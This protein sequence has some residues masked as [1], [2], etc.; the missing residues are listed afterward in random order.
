[1]PYKNSNHKI[2]NRLLIFITLFFITYALKAQIT[3][4]KA[5]PPSKVEQEVGLSKIT[6]DYS[7]PSVKGR[8]IFGDLVPYGR[9]WR[10]GANASTKITIDSEATIN[11]NTLKEGT[12]AIYA[13]PEVGEWEIV[14]HSN[15]DHWGDGRKAYDSKEDAFRIKVR[16][17]EIPYLQEN[18]LISFDD[19][20]HD[21]V[22]MQLLWE[23][24]KINIPISFDT[25]ELMQ[26]EILKKLG[27]VPI[28]D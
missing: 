5:S 19:V 14:F 3:H 16:P 10:V 1:M 2:Q 26:E 4:P 21:S 18:F 15:I 13:F 17:E 28:W 7:R 23:H 6:I 11:G 8:K 12:Y 22:T 9:I 24:T 27:V 20:T 25:D